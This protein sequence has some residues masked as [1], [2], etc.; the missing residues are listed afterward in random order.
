MPKQVSMQLTP[1]TDAQITDLQR[2]GFGTRTDV[3]RTAV[4]RMHQTETAKQHKENPMIDLTALGFTL[5]SDYP[6]HTWR[7]GAVSVQ[8]DNRMIDIGQEY[9]FSVQYAD[10]AAEG[11]FTGI[12]DFRLFCD[13]NG[14]LDKIAMLDRL[15]ATDPTTAFPFD[16]DGYTCLALDRIIDPDYG[17]CIWDTSIDDST[18][19]WQYPQN[20]TPSGGWHAV[21]GHANIYPQNGPAWIYKG[22]RCYCPAPAYISIQ[23]HRIAAGLPRLERSWHGS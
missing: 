1:A 12:S 8:R 14:V 16:C 6:H 20:R 21:N 11:P 2:I 4:D 5:V 3:V 13:V 19:H 18:I 17:E 7:R 10:G 9:S 22:T 23:A 15:A